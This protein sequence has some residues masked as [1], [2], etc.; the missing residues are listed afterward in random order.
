MPDEITIQLWPKGREVEAT[1]FSSVEGMRTILVEAHPRKF[2][3]LALILAR[4]LDAVW[5]AGDAD[6][7]PMAVAIPPRRCAVL[8]K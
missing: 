2:E 3:A 8:V 6:T 7:E 1:A 5:E 4:L